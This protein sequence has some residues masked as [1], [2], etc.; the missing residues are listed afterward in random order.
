MLAVLSNH[1]M[2]LHFAI[3][4]LVY[5]RQFIGC[6]V[7]ESQFLLMDCH[8]FALCPLIDIRKFNIINFVLRECQDCRLAISISM[9]SMRFF[10]SNN[11]LMCWHAI[12]F[13]TFVFAHSFAVFFYLLVQNAAVTFIRLFIIRKIFIRIMN[14]ISIHC[15]CCCCCGFY[16]RT[17]KC[18]MNCIGTHKAHSTAQVSVVHIYRILDT[19]KMDNNNR[20]IFV[21]NAH[22]G[23]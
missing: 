4:L 6:N 23:L 8:S 2:R 19:S 1:A 20:W 12:S 14:S 5:S 16:M 10:L 3:H 18:P 21:S 7:S 17:R 13:L 11:N 22:R 9:L 15:C